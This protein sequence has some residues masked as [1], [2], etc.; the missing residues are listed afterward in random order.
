VAEQGWRRGNKRGVVVIPTGGGKTTT[1]FEMF[2][3]F[4]VRNP[5]KRGVFFTERRILAQQAAFAARERGIDPGLHMAD[6]P[7]HVRREGIFND[8]SRPIQVASWQTAEASGHFPKADFVVVDEGHRFGSRDRQSA[9]DR[10]YPNAYLLYLSGSPVFP[11]GSTM[12]SVA[13]FLVNPVGVGPLVDRGILVPSR[14]K[15]PDLECLRG[16]NFADDAERMRKVMRKTMSRKML[17]ESPVTHW[18][19]HAQG[20]RTFYFGHCVADS[21]EVCRQFNAEGIQAV[22]VDADTPDEKR[23]E[24]FEAFREGRIKVIC[25][26]EVL[27]YGV[28][29]QEVECVILRCPVRNISGLI[30]RMGRGIRA[31]KGIDK[32]ECLFLDMA[33][34]TI[35][36]QYVPGVREIDWD[37]KDENLDAREDERVKSGE[38]D[39]LQIC[40]RCAAAFSSKKTRQCP[41][42]GW[43]MVRKASPLKVESEVVCSLRDLMSRGDMPDADQLKKLNADWVSFLY[44]AHHQNAAIGRA[45][46]MFGQKY[47]NPPWK[48]G[49]QPLP[50]TF[51]SDVWKKR[52]SE[53]FPEMF[54]SKEKSWQ[55]G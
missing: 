55:Q 5:G 16:M 11:D 14:V 45:L 44:V 28:D 49:L 21:R 53:L 32:T 34:V 8:P 3:R 7:E 9:I 31:C 6:V 20:K 15:Y 23:V 48:Y 40:P 43:K 18:K 51:S 26:Y 33:G 13:T 38:E 17:V 52:P 46:A 12:G 10:H 37:L 24:W 36:H 42:C 41:Q 47:G 50:K 54:R 35:Y 39:V 27:T 1:A 30:Q 4:L 22:H 19:K 29:V 25:N 2:R